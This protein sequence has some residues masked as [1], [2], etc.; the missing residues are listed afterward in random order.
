M[1]QFIILFICLVNLFSF[2]QSDTEIFLFDIDTKT[3]T[4]ELKNGKNLSNNEG[5]DNQPSFLNDRYILFA[6]TRN[7]QTDIAKY[8]MRYDSKSWLNFTEGGE[9]TPLKMP[10]KNKVSAVRL[11][12]DGKQRLYAYNISN[13]ESVELIPD[14]V[15]AYYTWLD[16]NTI[17]SAVIE[18]DNLNLYTT[19]LDD[20]RNRKY[21]TNVGRSFH[22]IPNSNLVSFIS[23]EDH[24]QWQIKALD[25]L[26]GNTLVIANTIDGVEDICWLDDKTMLSG[27]DSILYK[28]TV[29]KDKSWI[30]VSDLKSNEITKITRIAT[31]SSGTKL[32]IA[33][34]IS[35]VDIAKNPNNETS[36]TE[37]N[38]DT[39]ETALDINEDVAANIVQKH[40]EPFNNRNLEAFANA[41]DE[42]VSVNRFP[43]EKMYSGRNTL[44]ENYKQFFKNNKKSKVVILNRMTHNN[45][46]IDE[47]LVT[48]NNTTNRQVTIYDTD[49]DNINSMTFISNSKTTS[50]P[51]AIVNQQLEAY[52]NRNIDAFVDTYSADI[53]LYDFPN[54]L[55]SEGKDAIQKSYAS[56]F[57]SV[58]DLNAEIV[59]RIVLGNKVIDSE[60]VLI[61]GKVYNAIAI[62]EVENKLISKVT[63]I[64]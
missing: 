40:I 51:E 46:V 3:S 28:L 17:V 7:K 58:P 8:D 19:R 55:N 16:E 47:E 63:F 38:T 62:Y 52:N 61:N 39:S 33:A 54:K 15:V 32:L 45:I 14:L 53:K 6:S 26:T 36:S 22:K 42:N 25:P 59:N 20:N 23:K 31:D 24:T 48:V 4:I 18:E 57:N 29:G 10:N 34:E 27:K 21:A 56:F 60:K 43:S 5:Y 2:S 1:K 49:A 37:E 41:F 30:E 9:Y 35:K 64:H 13:G 11:D 12:A 50:N 44:K